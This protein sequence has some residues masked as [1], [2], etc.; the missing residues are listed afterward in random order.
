MSTDENNL[1]RDET[2]L[3]AGG[4]IKR[5]SADVEILRGIALFL[6]CII[7]GIF[8]SPTPDHFG[9]AEGIVGILLILAVGILMPI[10][11]FF[12]SNLPFWLRMGQVFLVFGLS[13][14][15]SVAVMSGQ[16]AGAITRDL[17]PFA[18]LFLPILMYPALEK[19][20]QARI[21]MLSG[22]VLIG[23]LFSIRSLSLRASSGDALLYLENMPSVLFACLF[24][25]GAAFSA[26]FRG[27]SPVRSGI[28][29]M[30]LALALLPFLAMFYS[31][32]RA[33][34]GAVVFFT[35]AMLCY[36]FIRSPGRAM[37]VVML[38]LIGVGVLFLTLGHQGI[39]SEISGSFAAL[40]DKSQK[41]G[42]N[43]RMQE[44]SAVWDMVTRD[45]NNFLFGMGW[46]AQFY[47]PAVG[48]LSVN[49]THNFFS[50]FL[51]KTGL[52]GV[53]CASA[54]I[55]GLLGV[56]VRAILKNPALGLALLAPIL[57]DLTLY[58]SFKSLDFGLT[59]LMIPLALL[60]SEKSKI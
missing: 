41:V 15:L 49:F 45:Q 47:S 16:E 11:Q 4:V 43:N 33:S 2:M 32:Q 14:P 59:L 39:L 21:L 27:V 56:L 44:F 30:T 8:G 22:I 25:I 58:A 52:I 23:L 50:Y 55:V 7:Y 29:Y 36:T 60:Y 12:I 42:L 40:E 53:L 5:E 18:F 13:V 31:L 20:T 37:N 17:I 38:V 46:G 3:P 26:A 57:I 9:I 24:L 35:M 1:R 10:K 34:I 48:G 51:L 19:S 28:F 6:A 54:Y